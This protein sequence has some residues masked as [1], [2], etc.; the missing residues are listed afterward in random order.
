[1]PCKKLRGFYLYA[2]IR[3]NCRAME[4]ILEAVRLT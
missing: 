3:G 1:M 2:G 4:S